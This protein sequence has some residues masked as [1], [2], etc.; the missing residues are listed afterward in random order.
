MLLDVQTFVH[1]SSYDLDALIGD[2]QEE[3]RR[4]TPSEATA[5]RNSLPALAIALQ[6]PDLA[7]FHVQVGSPPSIAV[8][9]RLPASTSWA[10]AV[11][12]GRNSRA[13]AAVI[14]ELK[15]W[16][17]TGDTPGPREGLVQHANRIVHHPS[18]QVRGYANYCRRFHSTVQDEDAEVA[19]CVYFTYAS[20]ASTYSMEPH[21]RL[22]AQFPVFARNQEDLEER[23]PAFIANWLEAP[24]LGFANGFARG[25]YRQDRA[26]VIQV[27]SAI[28]QSGTSP[29]ELLDQQRLGF[30]QCMRAVELA[31]PTSLG[32]RATDQPTKAVVV[33]QGPPGS[34]KSVV[35]AHLWATLAGRT[36][37]GDNAVLTTTS[38]S[39]KANWRHLFESVSPESGGAGLV[40]TANQYNPGLSPKWIKELR[41][42]GHPATVADWRANLR[43]F[44]QSGRPSRC[45]DN[46][47][48]VSIVDEA[49]GLI[50]PTAPGAEGVPPSG[51]AMHAGPQAWHIIRGSRVSVFLMDSA[52]SYRD[53]ETT[54]LDSILEHA[55]D[56]GVDH[57]E[58]VSLEGNQFR[59]AG[60]A[61]YLDWLD[62][63]LDQRDEQQ[64]NLS[65]RTRHGGPFT[66]ELVDTPGDLDD[67]LEVKRAAGDSCRLL[68]AY[69]RKWKTKGI[70]QP[71]N[72]APTDRDFQFTFD[73][74]N[75]PDEW[76]R[77]WNYA[78]D[79]DYTL[80]VQ[81]PPGSHMAE[82]C[83]AEV[84]C[85]YVVRG[86]DF[87][88]IGVLWLEDLVRRDDR[89]VA[90]FDHI[91]ESAWKKSLAAARRE[92]GGGPK[93]NEIVNRLLRGYRIL[94]S[95]AMK[96]AFVWCA[97]DETRRF[98]KQ[99]LNVD[100]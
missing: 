75:G 76:S 54:T 38:G 43:A 70:D 17:T 22:A 84:G 1:R 42:R 52:Q 13:P 33:I 47:F 87:D 2:L 64:P 97:D 26:F 36:D 60:A 14:V 23:F 27:A 45:P 94:L 82:D 93:T 74:P 37:L 32:G 91:H 51:W 95:R 73:G 29:F 25:A 4:K 41:E 8:E 92:P 3:T 79:Q 98:L 71:H 80:F 68:A 66:F 5:W 61:E 83:L 31:A 55:R 15:D 58:I 46:A 24:D 67:A 9:Y 28:K 49:H 39:Q 88:W 89:W 35:A 78:P 57:V 96:G 90:N 65:W 18:D 44:E 16:D 53:N 6:H 72:L 85:P 50:D 77:I 7:P 10:D 62:A 59:C 99:R 69:A 30:E 81:A 21:D 40:K 56:H 12:L 63:T 19:G 34:G 11:L 100:R 48:A 86:F 20:G